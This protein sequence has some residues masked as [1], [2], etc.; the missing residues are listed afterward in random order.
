MS[1]GRPPAKPPG[2][3]LKPPAPGARPSSGKGRGADTE[4]HA[5]EVRAVARGKSS[6]EVAPAGEERPAAFDRQDLLVVHAWMQRRPLEPKPVAPALV[7]YP[8]NWNTKRG[9]YC[10]FRAP[11]A[12]SYA[13]LRA[14]P[15]F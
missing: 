3:G 10:R 6:L 12:G 2:H 13:L 11:G 15:T 8:R 7:Q 5:Q 9:R 14:R 4:R 1:T